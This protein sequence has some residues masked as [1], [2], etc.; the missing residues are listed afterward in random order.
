MLDPANIPMVMPDE[1]LARY[2]FSQSHFSRQNG[3]VK[4][5]AFMPAPNGELSVTRHVNAT[6]H[7]IWA[8]GREI[9]K[10]R[11][12][13]LHGRGDVLAATCMSQR[14]TVVASP[15]HGNPNH[16]NVVDWPME[17]KAAQKL[18]AEEIAVAAKFV[19]PPADVNQ[20]LP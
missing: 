14:L 12:R 3:R 5:G 18:I 15:I 9:A 2:V 4:A 1:L 8:I 16:A 10:V 17:D 7:E 20:R 13:T 11:G 6:G 19:V